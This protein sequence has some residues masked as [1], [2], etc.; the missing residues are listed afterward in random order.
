MTR[1]ILKNIYRY[2][3]MITM[4]NI[5]QS[6][7]KIARNDRKVAKALT[8]LSIACIESFILCPVERLKVILMTRN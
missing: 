2:P 5:I 8:G 4:P 3:L 7:L 1:I 6:K